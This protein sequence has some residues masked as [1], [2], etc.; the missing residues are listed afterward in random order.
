MPTLKTAFNK[1]YFLFARKMISKSCGV[2]VVCFFIFFPWISFSQVQ[3]PN[4]IFILGDDIGY[5]VPTINGGKSYETPNIDTLAT[6]GAL[7]T[8]FHATPLCSPS[9]FMVMTGKYNFR[10]YRQW[11]I[12]DSTQRTF[13][14]MFKDAGYKTAVYGKWQMDGGDFSIKTFG[15]DDY[16]VW[17][18]L[19]SES[20][21]RYKNPILYTHGNFI[22]DSATLNEYSEDIICDSLLNF[23]S[24]N[25][26]NPFFVYYPMILGHVPQSPT[27]DDPEFANWN[28]ALNLTDTSFFPSM[29]KYMD[30]K[31]G[32]IIQKVRDLGI[33]NNTIIIFSGDNGTSKRIFSDFDDSTIAGGKTQTTETGTHVPLMIYWK[34]KIAPGIIN[35]QLSD[36]TDI[37]PTFAELANIPIPTDYGILDGVSFAPRI[38]GNRSPSRDW[39]F[40]HFDPN[41]AAREMARWVQNKRYKLYDSISTSDKKGLFFKISNDPNEKNPLKLKKLTPEQDSIRKLFLDVLLSYRGVPLFLNPL[42]AGIT[43]SSITVISNLKSNGGDA[44]RDRGI[45][46]S[47]FPEP[48]VDNGTRISQGKLVKAFSTTIKRL[49]SFTKYYIRSYAINSVG[50]AYS[51]QIEV[52]TTGK[53]LAPVAT[54]SANIDS[55]LFT[56]NWTPVADAEYYQLDVSTYPNFVLPTEQNLVEGFDAGIT[57]SSGWTINND[58]DI[59]TIPEKFGAASPALKFISPNQNVI[60]PFL[61]GIATELSFWMR[62]LSSDSLN[63]FIVEGFNGNS[64]VLIDSITKIPGRPEVKLY[65]ASTNQPFAKN[66]FIKFKF[67]YRKIS[68]NLAFDD[69]SIKYFVPSYIPGYDSLVVSDTTQIVNGLQS[70]NTYY[71][72]IRS[73][74]LNTKSPNSNIIVTNTCTKPKLNFII[75]EPSCNGNN[76]GMIFIDKSADTQS[77]SYVWTGPSDFSSANKD[78]NG[79]IKGNYNLHASVNG[80][81]LFDTII[82]VSEPTVI[83]A[84]ENHSTITC[85]G[86]KSTV[87][88]SAEGGTAPYSGTG[89]FNQSAG[90]TSYIITDANGCTSTIDV[91]VSEPEELIASESHT[92][93]GQN[94]ET[95][96][97]TIS[98]NGGVL[99]YSGVGDFTQNA[100]TAYYNITDANGC[101]A[102]VKVSVI[103]PGDVVANENHTTISCHGE[104]SIITISADGGN[105]PYSGTGDFVQSAGSAT[106][107]VTDANGSSSFIQVVLTEPDSLTVSEIHTPIACYNEQ[108]SVTI[109]GS[110]GTFPYNG[111]GVYAQSAGTET[112][113]INDANGCSTTIDVTTSQPDSLIV[114]ETHE[115]I[116]CNNDTSLVAITVSGGIAPYVGNGNF[117]QNYGTKTYTVADANGCSTSTDVTVNALNFVNIPIAVDSS[118]CGSGKVTIAAT[119][120]SNTVIDWYAS[121]SNGIA[122]KTKSSNYTTQNISSSE[123]YYAAARDTITGCIS[124]RTAVTAIVI[125]PPEKP[126]G[127]DTTICGTNNA[128]LSAT[129]SA[130]ETVDWYSHAN[131]GISLISS[132]GTYITPVLSSNKTYYAAARNII[133]GCKSADRLPVTVVINNLPEVPNGTN[134][135]SCGGAPV[136]IA[137]S[138]GTNE[139]IDWYSA[140]TA[141]ILLQSA[142]FNYTTPASVHNTSY[143]ATARNLITGC[144][145]PRKEIVVFVKPTITANSSTNICTGDSVILTSNIATGNQW[146][147]DGIAISGATFQNYAATE[148]GIYTVTNTNDSGCR[149]TSGSITVTTTNCAKNNL[150][151]KTGN[152]KNTQT[153]LHISVNPNPANKIFFLSI[154]GGNSKEEIEIIVLDVYGKPVFKTRGS[155]TKTYTFGEMLSAGTYVVRVLQGNTVKLIK[156]VKSN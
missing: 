45:V 144:F 42:L 59:S 116:N 56:A 79:L 153:N 126:T 131:G 88:L 128:T 35:D 44:L 101:A 110:G 109:S 149:A 117:P 133:N 5:E 118:V 6:E 49:A 37:L 67:T 72:R 24:T 142:S 80:G 61:D 39:I 57:P 90:T 150:L 89:V 127:N 50:I 22:G 29:V 25:K 121:S 99:P 43:D 147:K 74:K 87:N 14:N 26:D 146:K 63:S 156:V 115:I 46:W 58:I 34:G 47:T 9:R 16:I 107:T 41:P 129:A 64:W 139:T 124:A 93:I 11:G 69:I 40:C 148:N 66:K 15:F 98:G 105:T 83:V 91:T 96:F 54:T 53:L 31:I 28:P 104:T 141:G 71:S 84:K 108:S 95:S 76:N 143:F 1:G 145:S 112:Y 122:L 123:T 19:R 4:I 38:L 20:Q 60:T 82:S 111:I 65:N 94:N 21:S 151:S 114:S 97:V 85:K 138:A 30:K 92:A 106:Y 73:V 18:P 140:S 130:N 8:Q 135:Y 113:V 10:N 68:G 154:N 78:I 27:P 77:I 102:S 55:N 86:G 17:D 134:V 7:F 136:N 36:F 119:S 152:T 52:T 13:G 51:N 48:T 125:T 81:C 132:S 33:E 100:G 137:A 12:M 32:L 70:G 75:T 3:R 2:F 155:I 62:G 103:A 120:D 23:L